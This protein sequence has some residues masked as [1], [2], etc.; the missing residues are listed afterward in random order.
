VRDR[1]F[2]GAEPDR[3][4]TLNKTPLVRWNRRYAYVSSTHQILPRRLHDV[5]DPQTHGKATGVLL[6]TK[7]LPVIG[8]KSAE[9]I[10]RKQHFE[11]SNLYADYHAQLAANPTLWDETSAQYEGAGK[12]V[13]QGLMSKGTWV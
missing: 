1:V 5:F 9:E 11:N 4:P 6:H 13:A 2:F 3:A 10:A 8:E 12:L 7:F